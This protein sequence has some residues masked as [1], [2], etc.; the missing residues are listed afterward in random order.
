MFSYNR[1][2]VPMPYEVMTQV[3]YGGGHRLAWGAVL[4]WV[5]FA[6]HKGYGGEWLVGF[7]LVI[8]FHRIESACVGSLIGTTLDYTNSK[9]PIS[10]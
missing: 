6:C 2:V 3:V 4:A 9:Q 8:V 5:V 10:S 7:V 1:V